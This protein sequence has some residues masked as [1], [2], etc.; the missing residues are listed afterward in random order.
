MRIVRLAGGIVWRKSAGGPLLAVI[1]R[2][3]QADWSLPKGRA[4]EGE[5]WEEAA[6]REVAEETS[7]QAKIE[8]FA[9]AA[10]DVP[11]RSPRLALYWNM[12]LQEERRFVPGNEVDQLLWL[13]PADAIGRLDHE[14]ERRLLRRSMV[15]AATPPAGSPTGPLAAAVAATRADVLRRLFHAPTESGLPGLGPALELLEQAEAALGRSAEQEAAML[16]AGAR[17]LI[18]LSKEEPELSLRARSLREE[19]G[20]LPPWRRRAIRRLLPR[21]ERASAE[22]VLVA[23]ELRDRA[24]A[25]ALSLPALVAALFAAAS[26]ALGVAFMLGARGTGLWPAVGGAAAGAAIAALVLWGRRRG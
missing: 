17:R 21:R 19:A 16:A 10:V 23:T 6:L 14:S 2:P 24:P 8:S 26:A 7:C 18:L 15:R 11:R 13:S 5:T 12:S 1:H 25:G 22:A 3:R 4:D 9:G 20:S